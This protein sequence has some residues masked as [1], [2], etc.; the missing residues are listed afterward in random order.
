MHKKLAVHVTSNLH[1]CNIYYVTGRNFEKYIE[2]NHVI[3]G[4]GQKE[5]AQEVGKVARGGLGAL[6]V[7]VG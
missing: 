7:E 5:L 3:L 4:K 1:L 2:L 6:S